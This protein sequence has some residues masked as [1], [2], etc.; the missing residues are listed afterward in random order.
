V[1][2]INR[3]AEG[4]GNAVYHKIAAHLLSARACHEALGTM[5]KF[6]QYLMVL[7]MGQKRKKNLINILEQNGL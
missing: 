7:K 4:S 3:L 1:K 6:R 5:D 2:A